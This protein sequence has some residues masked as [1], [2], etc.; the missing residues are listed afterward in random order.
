MLGVRL[1]SER[2]HDKRRSA[3]TALV[4]NSAEFYEDTFRHFLT[5][6]ESAALCVPYM[7]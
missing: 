1:Q 6:S 2:S 7:V 3:R 4:K 5:H